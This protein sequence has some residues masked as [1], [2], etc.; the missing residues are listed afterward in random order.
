MK[1]TSTSCPGKKYT[2]I[3]G[4][5]SIS[6]TVMYV[7]VYVCMYVCRHGVKEGFPQ[8]QLEL[9]NTMQSEKQLEEAAMEHAEEQRRK[10]KVSN[11]CMLS[12]LKIIMYPLSPLPRRDMHY[13]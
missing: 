9:G 7:C 12:L 11:L 6:A 3:V 4:F 2:C 10:L 8:R 5:V 13:V 1:F